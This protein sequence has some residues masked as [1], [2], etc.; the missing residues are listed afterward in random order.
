MKSEINFCN[1][2]LLSLPS[3]SASNSI[4]CV[5][6]RSGL[7]VKRCSPPGPS[8]PRP[9]P[10]P[11]DNW[12]S[13]PVFGLRDAKKGAMRG[14]R[15]LNSQLSTPI[16]QLSSLNSHPS[17][18]IPHRS[19]LI[20]QPSTLNPQPSTLNPQRLLIPIEQVHLV[21]AQRVPGTCLDAL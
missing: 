10:G 15:F 8:G 7:N 3:L 9:S 18:L 2:S 19:S 5:N 12:G 11:R 13:D 16:P 17:S 21:G 6:M 14:L 4:A 20:P 1:S